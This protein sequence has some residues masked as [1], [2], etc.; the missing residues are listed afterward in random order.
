MNDY[1]DRKRRYGMAEQQAAAARSEIKSAEQ[2]IAEE[3]RY[4]SIGNVSS[5]GKADYERFKREF[6]AASLRASI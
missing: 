6:E 1:L 3:C 2:I 4:G 5:E